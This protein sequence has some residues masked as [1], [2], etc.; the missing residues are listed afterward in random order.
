MRFSIIYNYQ[1]FT[2]WFISFS[3]RGTVTDFSLVLLIFCPNVLNV[4]AWLDK[5]STGTYESWFGWELKEPSVRE[6]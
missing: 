3:N 2:K 6:V 4:N 5:V 1:I